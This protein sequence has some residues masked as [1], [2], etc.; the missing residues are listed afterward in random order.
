MHWQGVEGSLQGPGPGEME[1]AGG[2]RSCAP[3]WEEGAGT[4]TA[5]AL[6]VY[7][8]AACML[9]RS[10]SGLGKLAV[11]GCPL[12]C[13]LGQTGLGGASVRQ[14]ESFEPF[15]SFIGRGSLGH[16]G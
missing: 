13:L 15:E 9:V 4:G 7:G 12:A 3:G 1:G 14:F 5:K 2:G 16:R 10:L 8:L 6:H 11:R